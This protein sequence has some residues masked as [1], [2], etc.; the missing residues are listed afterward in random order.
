MT[1]IDY[2]LGCRMPLAG[3]IQLNR[4]DVFA[5]AQLKP[6]VAPFPPRELMQNV[7]GLVSQS[8][9]ASHGCDFF[10]AL[11]AAS[12][13]PLSDYRS[14]LD[15][16]CGV[17]R[18]ARM[19]KGHPGTIAGC[20]IDHR[21]V[22]W[23]DAT[24][25][26]VDAKLSGVTPPIPY[27]DSEFE[28]LISISIFTHLN[29]ASQNQLLAELAR[30]TAQDGLLF[31]TVHGERA[32]QRATDEP[33]IRAMIDVPDAPFEKAKADFAAGRHAFILQNGHLT[34]TLPRIAGQEKIVTGE[35][36]YG[37]TFIPEAYLRAHWSRWFEVVDYRSGALHDFQDLAVLRPKARSQEPS[38]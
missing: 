17:G 37:I 30:V 15:F 28:A 7:S 32:L 6:Y 5:D 22:E 4:I 16:G 21:H 19:F 11:S 1:A 14:I 13:K 38:S 2:S 29:E 18:L 34:T 35:F 3:W 23:V 12:P 10:I 25:D 8:D 36:E 24:L 26:F 9:F 33:V 20:D 31:L 27:E